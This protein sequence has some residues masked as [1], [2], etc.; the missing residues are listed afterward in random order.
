MFHGRSCWRRGQFFAGKEREKV[1]ARR[2]LAF[3][4]QVLLFRGVVGVADYVSATGRS[5]EAGNCCSHRNTLCS[6][7]KGRKKRIHRIKG[8]GRREER[9]RIPWGGYFRREEWREIVGGGAI[10]R[11]RGGRKKIFRFG[12]LCIKLGRYRALI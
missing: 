2:L 6:E 3:S 4:V 5:L 9:L 7:E 12:L 10:V 1:G 8:E 11:A